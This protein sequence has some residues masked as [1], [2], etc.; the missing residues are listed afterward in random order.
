M[1]EFELMNKYGAQVSTFEKV[2][3][4]FGWVYGTTFKELN[5]SNKL[6]VGS[7]TQSS[8]YPTIL[9]IIRLMRALNFLDME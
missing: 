5:L 4:F 1:I 3:P 7:P 6:A 8:T 9:A 2:I